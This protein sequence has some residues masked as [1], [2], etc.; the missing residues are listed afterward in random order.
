MTISDYLLQEKN[1]TTVPVAH[2][3]DEQIHTY[4]QLTPEFVQM[5]THLKTHL[6]R[7][8]KWFRPA[9]ALLG[10]RLAGGINPDSVRQNV[11]ALELLHRYLLIH[12]DIIDQDL[13]RHGGPTMEQIYRDEN[14]ELFGR[15]MAIVAG[16]VTNAMAYELLNSGNHRPE[17]LHAATLGF[18]QLLMETSAGWQLQTSQNYQTID[19]VD[20]AS[21]LLGMKLVSAQY[22]VVWPL[23]I[24]QLFAGKTIWNSDLDE[25]GFHAG[26]SF[27]ITDDILG[28]FGDEKKTGKPVGHDYR[29]GKKTLLVSRAYREA[30]EEDRAFIKTTLGTNVSPEEVERVRQIMIDTGSLS[31][32]QR[33]AREHTASAKAAL[34]RVSTTDTEAKELLAGLADLFTQRDF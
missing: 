16:D 3:L 22:S 17:I 11:G 30:S 5:L 14:G 34:R 25:Y 10:Y 28:M 13:T 7:G 2:F 27:Q 18:N 12:D 20:E 8:G 21:F 32:S 9:L 19:Q 29:E 24:G 15:N 31:Y 4:Q 23:R 33:L 26:M 6:L 1:K